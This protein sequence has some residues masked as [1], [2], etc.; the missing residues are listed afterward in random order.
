MEKAV[1]CRRTQIVRD[2][3][4]KFIETPAGIIVVTDDERGPVVGLLT[5]HDLLRAQ[6]AMSE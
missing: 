1:T 3:A 2:V 4:D 5:L 6:A